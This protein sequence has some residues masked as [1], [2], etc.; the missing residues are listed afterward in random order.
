LVSRILTVC[1]SALLASSLAAQK[2]ALEFTRQGLLITNFATGPGISSKAGR[3]AADEVRDHVAKLS[4]KKELEV[5]SGS[6]IRNKLELSGYRLDTPLVPSEVRALAR[7]MRADELV[8]GEIQRR[9]GGIR[10][11]GSLVLLRDERQAQPLAPADGADIGKAAAEMAK[12]IAAARRQLAPQRRCENHIRDGNSTRAVQSAREGVTAYPRSTLARTCLIIAMR[13]SGFPATEVLQVAR[14]QL[15]IDSGSF[16]A[17]DA[18]APALD[19][20]RRREE[21]AQ[22]WLRLAATDTSDLEL[23]ERVVWSLTLGGNTRHAEPLIV[24]AS[25]AHPDNLRL[26]RQKWRVLVD[27]RKWKDAIVVGE[28]MMAKDTEAVA[29]SSFHLRLAGAYKATNQT[30]KAVE[31][32]SHGVNAFPGDSRL[33]AFYTQLV[34]GEADVVL[35]RGLEL[36]PRNAELHAMN[37]KALKERG[38]LEES[39]ASSRQAVALD[40]SLAQGLLMIAQTELELGR[41]DS[42]LAAV[43]RALNLGEETRLVAQFA[44]SKGNAFFRAAN[45]TKRREDFQLAMRFL[46]VADSLNPSPQS[47]FL[48]GASAFSVAT[49][50]LTDAPKIAETDKVKGCELSRLGGEVLPVAR[51]GLE[52]GT[53][54]QPDAVKQYLD[55]LVELA[56]FVDKQTAAFCV[57]DSVKTNAAGA[58]GTPISPASDSRP[59]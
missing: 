6:A 32:A 45:G 39:L 28:A 8:V 34:R 27:N 26:L 4:N 43:H 3:E 24:R 21:A 40:S 17:L 47:K 1:A 30:L 51:A 56:P 19:S 12:Q 35:P 16:H 9:P 37:A 11:S 5:I 25:D 20:L 36:F 42:A 22:M 41:P 38:K 10:L 46:A 49:M 54:I 18:A 14:E 59:Q 33:Y 2:Q 44:L 13:L 53:E 48:L 58:A 7:Q 29:D 23:T 50:A 31:T 57:G 52:G 15:A 55:Y